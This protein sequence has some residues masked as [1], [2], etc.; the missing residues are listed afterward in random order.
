MT[1]IP[2]DPDQSAAIVESSSDAVIGVTL[3][4]V[5]TSWNPAAETLLGYTT[6]EA[7]QQPIDLIVPAE[8]RP[9]AAALLHQIGRGSNVEPFETVYLTKAGRAIDVS[10]AV[11]PILDADGQIIGTA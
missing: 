3:E 4:G 5:I 10:V 11:S 7:V 2:D 9:Q 8:R 6:A 1:S